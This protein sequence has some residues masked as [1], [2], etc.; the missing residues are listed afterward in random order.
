MT[1]D[2]A[3][4]ADIETPSITHPYHGFRGYLIS[5]AKAWRQ[6]GETVLYI[7]VQR[8]AIHTGDH[9]FARID[10]NPTSFSIAC[11]RLRIVNLPAQT[12]VQGQLGRDTPGILPVEEL[13]IL[14][15]TG[16]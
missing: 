9:D 8:D 4:G 14:S 3:K 15:F 11:Y 13:A 1:K 2:R 12:V 5:N 6:V 10:V 16:I 7:A